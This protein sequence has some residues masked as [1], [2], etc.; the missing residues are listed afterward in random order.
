[1]VGTE[2]SEIYSKAIKIDLFARSDASY[3]NYK[4]Q[5]HTQNFDFKYWRFHKTLSYLKLSQLTGGGNVIPPTFFRQD[6]RIV[7]S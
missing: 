1:M 4:I 3:I 7:C 2:I 6:E 5:E